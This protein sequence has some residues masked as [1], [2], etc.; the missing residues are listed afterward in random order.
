MQQSSKPPAASVSCAAVGQC[1]VWVQGSVG[2]SAKNEA[3]SSAE[4]AISLRKA[5]VAKWIAGY[6]AR[7]AGDA[8]TPAAP[9]VDKAAAADIQKRKKEAQAWITKWRKTPAPKAAAPRAAASGNGAGAPAAAAKPAAA[10]KPSVPSKAAIAAQKKEAQEWIAN[11]RANLP[12]TPQD[13]VRT[14]IANWRAG[15]HFLP[16]AC[17]SVNVSFLILAG[18]ECH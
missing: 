18:Y 4:A 1:V 3:P 6:R 16:G 11:Y 8:A 13:E 5:D 14:W 17:A 7:G 15:E 9:A 12:A 10:V 2:T